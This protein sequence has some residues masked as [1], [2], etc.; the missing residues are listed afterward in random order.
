MN[1]E[2]P[3][4]RNWLKTMGFGMGSLLAAGSSARWPDSAAAS[5]ATP[6]TTAPAQSNGILRVAHITDVHVQP[7]LRGGEGMTACLRQ[8]KRAALRATKDQAAGNGAV[9]C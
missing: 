9:R 1:Q 2:N 5:P 7:E 4:R 8:A 3:T 6:A